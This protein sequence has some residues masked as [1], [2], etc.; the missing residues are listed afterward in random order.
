MSLVIVGVLDLA[1]L[2]G[3]LDVTLPD[4]DVLLQLSNFLSE[5]LDGCHG[6]L[7]VGFEDANVVIGLVDGTVLL[8]SGVI[9]ELLVSCE[10]S[11]LLM[12]LLLALLEHG[13]HQLQNFLHRGDLCAMANANER[14]CHCSLHFARSTEGDLES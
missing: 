9:A 11:L 1:N 8:D 2:S 14:K 12:F 4:G 7:D 13:V 10:C 6:L 3:C 5:L